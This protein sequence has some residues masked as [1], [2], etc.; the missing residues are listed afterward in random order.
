MRSY[1]EVKIML[2]SEECE[3]LENAAKILEEIVTR[4][5]NNKCGYM[6]GQTG[7]YEDDMIEDAQLLLEFLSQAEEELTVF[8]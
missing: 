7:D 8:E 1:K 2:Y 5:R 4:M 3:T 6:Q